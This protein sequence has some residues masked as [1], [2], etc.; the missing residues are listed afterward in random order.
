MKKITKFQVYKLSLILFIFILSFTFIF[1]NKIDED[2]YNY[3]YVK[4][5]YKIVT[6]TLPDTAYFAGQL[7]DLTDPYI[8]ERVEYELYSIAYFHSQLLKTVK[9]TD[10][11]LPYIENELK[12]NKLPI[13]LKYIAIIESNL[14]QATSPAGAKGIWQFMKGTAIKYGLEVND[15]VDERLNF[16]KSTKAAL[17]YL[18]DLHNMFGDW[19]LAIAAYNAGENYIK[20]KINEQYTNNLWDL[21]INA[22]TARYISRAI[23]TKLIFQS[24]KNFGFYIPT[25]EI[26]PKY[27]YKE[28]EIDSSIKSL[29]YFCKERDISY[30]NFKKLNPW[31][32]SDKLTNSSK[33]NYIIRIPI[34]D[35]YQMHKSTSYDSLELIESI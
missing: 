28:I 1:S 11:Y 33:K 20:T 7:V 35:E 12:N 10:R 5:Q 24:L 16:E 27:Q 6:F 8:R 19:F 13:D 9:Q 21:V 32:I 14:M 26:Y 15:D 2:T 17:S 23:A 3:S 30:Y 4:E 29:P 34:S 25:I 31:L 18:K 22:E